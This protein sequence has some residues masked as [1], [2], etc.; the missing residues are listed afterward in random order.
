MLGISDPPLVKTHVL[1]RAH[2]RVNDTPLSVS[3]ERRAALLG[4]AHGL[5]SHAPGGSAELP[6]TFMTSA[7]QAK[8]A[9]YLLPDDFREFNEAYVQ[10]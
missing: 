10:I 7:L 9:H 3:S 2:G 1:F 5:P 6:F 4:G 8:T